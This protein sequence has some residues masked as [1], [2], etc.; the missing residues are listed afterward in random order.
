[1][2]ARMPMS[3]AE[4]RRAA[5]PRSAARMR[6]AERKRLLLDWAKQLFAARGYRETSG[7]AIAAA[8]GVTE[9]VLYRHFESKKALLLEILQEVRKAT[10]ERWQG[11]TAALT[12]PLARLHAVAELYFH[13]TRELAVELRVLHRA[14]LESEDSDV[15]PFLQALYLDAEAYL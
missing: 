5:A 12:D 11:E 15:A 3:T 2:Q 10:L 1:R 7:E 9:A 8:A 4:R 14:L 13:A 6:A